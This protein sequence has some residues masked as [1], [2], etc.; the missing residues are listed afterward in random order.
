[1]KKQLLT[2]V[3]ISLIFT[4]CS[5]KE[6]TPESTIDVTELSLNYDK[7]HQFTI[8]QGNNDIDESTY[9]WTSADVRV[10]TIEASGLFQAKRIGTTTVTATKD[11]KSLTSKI[12]VSPYV[13]F[14]IEPYVS[15]TSNKTTIKSQET[16]PLETGGETTTSLLY[17]GE[18]NK[19]TNVFYGFENGLLQGSIVVFNISNI[20]PKDLATFF[21]ERYTLIGETNNTYYFSKGDI[22]VAIGETAGIGFTAIYVKNTTGNVSNISVKEAKLLI[23][24][25]S[26]ILKAELN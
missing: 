7:Q 6:S 16:R 1:M 14:F 18:N 5:K 20:L 23:D 25:K 24:Q 4:A 22:L 12:T 2:L 21:V 9:I 13:Y 11:G 19:I 15:F 3:A 17:K 8:K 26:L 10:G